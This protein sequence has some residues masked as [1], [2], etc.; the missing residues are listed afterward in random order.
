MTTYRFRIGHQ[1]PN[2]RMKTT[3][4][5]SSSKD[6]ALR[7]FLA[8]HQHKKPCDRPQAFS[9]CAILFSAEEVSQP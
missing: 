6:E 1:T 8:R 3:T 2:G 5:R 7:S 4:L 9:I